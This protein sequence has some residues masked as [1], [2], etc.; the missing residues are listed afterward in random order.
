MILTINEAMITLF[1]LFL[2]TIGILLCTLFIFFFYHFIA[3]RDFFDL[4]LQQHSGEAKWVWLRKTLNILFYI[5]EYIILLP[6]FILIWFAVFAV[7]ILL[8]SDSQN[9]THI[10]LIAMAIVTSIRVATYFHE[11]LA[12]ELAKLLPLILLAGL[13]VGGTS[14]ISLEG[15][16]ETLLSFPPYFKVVLYYLLFAIA[17]EFILRIGIL[18]F[19][20]EEK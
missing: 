14:S 11:E 13:L 17:I 12:K 10:L 19:G 6:V 4:N 20:K 1:P 9:P 15:I 5:A 16:G 7:I 3:N 8:L 18:L 2:L